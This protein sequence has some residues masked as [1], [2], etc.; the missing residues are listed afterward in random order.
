[1]FLWTIR[2]INHRVTDVGSAFNADER[3]LLHSF[4]AYMGLENKMECPFVL[5]VVALQQIFCKVVVFFLNLLVVKMEAVFYYL[6]S[7][8]NILW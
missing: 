3:F 8:H 2:R 5:G 7:E 1:M 6:F 4:H